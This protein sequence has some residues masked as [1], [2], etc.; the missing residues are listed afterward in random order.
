LIF[1]GVLLLIVGVLLIAFPKT[2]WWLNYGWAFK[3]AE[4][5]EL[6]IGYSY[7]LGGIAVFFG[8]IMIIGGF[9]E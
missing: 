8:L 1:W 3:N 6:A 2:Q 5:S 7:M 9:L 4:P